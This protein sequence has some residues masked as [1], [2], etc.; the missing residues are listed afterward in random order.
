MK[1]LFIALALLMP[2]PA[3]ADLSNYDVLS[4]GRVITT[5]KKEYPNYKFGVTMIVDYGS[6]IFECSIYQSKLTCVWVK[7]LENFPVHL[8]DKK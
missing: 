3:L 4:K 1:R 7:G 6:R 5:L 8:S 2:I